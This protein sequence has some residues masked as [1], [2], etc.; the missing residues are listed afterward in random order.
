MKRKRMVASLEYGRCFPLL[1]RIFILFMLCFSCVG[2]PFAIIF[3]VPQS[4]IVYVILIDVILFAI[5]L[6]LALENYKTVFLYRKC[7]KDGVVLTAKSEVTDRSDEL[8]G[9]I[10]SRAV[11]IKVTFYLDGVKYVR[12]SG[13]K[14]YKQIFDGSKKAGYDNAFWRYSDREINILYS[15]KY[16][17]VFILKD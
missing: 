1:I 4:E 16:D 15:P 12:R 5:S 11:R 17:Q 10:R 3:A 13:Q 6:W 14:G 2:M 7:L 9:L 8:L